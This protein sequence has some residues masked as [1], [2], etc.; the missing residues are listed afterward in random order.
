[1]NTSTLSF[2]GRDSGFGENNNSAYLEHNNN[3]YIIDCGFTVFNT[4]KNKFDFKKYNSINSL[5]NHFI[6]LKDCTQ[7]NIKKL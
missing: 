3:L 1:M 2:L 6:R 4:I 5:Y 7:K